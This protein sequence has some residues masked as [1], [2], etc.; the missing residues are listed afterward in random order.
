M[1]TAMKVCATGQFF[2]EIVSSSTRCVTN[3]FL[4]R[5]GMSTFKQ[6]VCLDREVFVKADEREGICPPIVRPWPILKVTFTRTQL[7]T[8]II[9][10]FV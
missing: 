10:I 9:E 5:Q 4:S 3:G 7:F 1:L 2:N 6:R 8:G